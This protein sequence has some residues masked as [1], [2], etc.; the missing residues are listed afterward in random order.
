M[1]NFYPHDGGFL[2]SIQRYEPSLLFVCLFVYVSNSISWRTSSDP[3][4]LPRKSLPASRVVIHFSCAKWPRLRSEGQLGCL[5]GNEKKATLYIKSSFLLNP[6]LS[7]HRWESSLGQS[8]PGLPCRKETETSLSSNSW[9]LRKL[10]TISRGAGSSD[11]V[12]KR[13]VSSARSYEKDTHLLWP[14][15]EDSFFKKSICCAKELFRSSLI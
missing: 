14:Q 12:Q 1:A 8:A 6:R 11:W 4:K 13:A 9:T 3:L 15:Q 2:L 10:S 5:L 7:F